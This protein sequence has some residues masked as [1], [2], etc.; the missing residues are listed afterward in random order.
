MRNRCYIPD[1]VQHASARGDVNSE[2][3]LVIQCH[4][5]VAYSHRILM[6]GRILPWNKGGVAKKK[7][8]TEKVLVGAR[9]MTGT[10]DL[11]YREKRMGPPIE[12]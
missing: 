7:P 11:V 5:L 1:V 10:G 8:G 4:T 6:D 2:E 9:L 12:P 3:Q